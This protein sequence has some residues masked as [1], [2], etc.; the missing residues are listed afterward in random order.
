MTCFDLFAQGWT[1]TPVSC[2]DEEGVEGWRWES[3]DG[4]TEYTVMGDWSDDPPVPD[5]LDK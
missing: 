1:A 3:P 5:E 4:E 2:Y